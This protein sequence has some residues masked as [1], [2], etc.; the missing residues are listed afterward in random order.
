MPVSA[1][2]SYSVIV[3]RQ[4]WF[5]SVETY[6][7]HMGR[8]YSSSDGSLHILKSNTKTGQ[9]TLGSYTNVL[10]EWQVPSGPRFDTSIRIYKDIPSVALFEQCFPDGANDTATD[11]QGIISSFPALRPSW[12]QAKGVTIWAD[13][14]GPAPWPG[15]VPPI[16]GTLSGGIGGTGP[17]VV[18]NEDLS[19]S[20]VMS[21]FS[22][23]MAHA[24]TFSDNTMRFGVIGSAT[25]VPPGFCVT[26]ILSVGKGVNSAM[27]S[28]GDVLLK[29]HQ[30]ARYGY[31]RDLANQYLG[32]STDNGAYY[33]YHT[34]AGKNYEETIIDVRADAEHR[35][36]PYKYVLLDSW[37][38]YQGCD[39][40]CGVVAWDARPDIFPDGLSGLQS[41]TRWPYQLH[42]KYWD[43]KTTY[44]KQNGG[45]FEFVCD[46]DAM[47][48]PV[49]QAFWNELIANKSAAGMFMYEQDWQWIQFNR[50]K[51]LHEDPTLGHM[52]M[53]QMNTAAA[54]HN[55]TMQLCMT[56]SRQ[57]LQSVEMAQVTNIRASGDYQP[58][59]GD[60]DTAKDA[61]YYHA[62]GTAPSK[63]T[64]WSTAFQPGNPRYGNATEP[65]SRLQSVAASLT[66]GPIAVSDKIGSA[67]A[68]I[69]LRACDASGRL[70]TPD[71][72]ATYVDE[73]F[74]QKAFA[75]GGPN[76]HLW[77]TYASVG[78]TQFQYLLGIDL[79][80]AYSHRLDS[81][82]HSAT[83]LVATE[84]DSETIQEVSA[85]GSF[86][87]PQ[88]GQAD[89]K[90]VLISPILHGYALLGEPDKWVSVSSQRFSDLHFSD[91]EARVSVQ[92]EV[93]ESVVVRW[94][95]AQKVVVSTCVMPPSGQMCASIREEAAM[96]TP[97]VRSIF[98]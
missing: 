15:T 77:S 59:N 35:G 11:P 2:G 34:E 69:I 87:F 29:W 19:E 74:L 20:V 31:K 71:R 83:R 9:D 65:H 96:C 67:N 4:E 26:T 14:K 55:V 42:N 62:I 48:L 12:T 73:M 57:V 25:F 76:G 49:E 82:S 70:L 47:C 21:A 5:H 45:R 16:D 50:T 93:G 80:N 10:L 8:D 13:S 53:M 89:F 90:L 7:R 85:H 6:I 78:A 60:W 23:I 3:N 46:G 86:D 32:Y 84:I 72:P 38:Y 66:T 17:L 58:G 92:G 95:V 94:W 30:K 40:G 1:A 91:G 51:Q 81:F 22:N 24:Q 61:I 41:K 79:L 64:Y 63:D 44:A 75:K 18:F 39:N 68:S 52:W 28:W 97:V 27:E 54:T 56:Y 37:W 36:L 33:Y 88:C 98:V 43:A